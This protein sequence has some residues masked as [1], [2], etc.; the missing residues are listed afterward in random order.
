MSP[1]PRVKTLSP[2]LILLLIKIGTDRIDLIYLILL[3]EKFLLETPGIG[4]S[5]AE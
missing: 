1:A 3:F 5:P 2:G 4:S